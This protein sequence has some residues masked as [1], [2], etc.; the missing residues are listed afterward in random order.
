MS[1]IADF[2]NI[3]EDWWLY[4]LFHN[5]TPI[6]F[7]GDKHVPFNLSGHGEPW[8]CKLQH[9]DGGK[10]TEGRGMT[11]NEAIRDA[12]LKVQTEDW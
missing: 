12:I 11:P 7:R 2:S 8:S 1:Q 9:V 3:P 6:K 5:H 4:G 10:L